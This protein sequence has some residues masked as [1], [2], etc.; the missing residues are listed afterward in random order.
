MHGVIMNTITPDF[1]YKIAQ[2]INEQIRLIKQLQGFYKAAL[3]TEDEATL[4]EL[5]KKIEQEEAF[6]EELYNIR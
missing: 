5:D 6:L 1:N 3:L 2:H 4:K